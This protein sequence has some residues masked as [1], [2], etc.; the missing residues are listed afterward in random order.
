MG[1]KAK[2]SKKASGVGKPSS[3]AAETI[4]SFRLKGDRCYVEYRD[5]G[6][7]PLEIDLP[8]SEV[9]DVLSPALSEMAACRGM[10][11]PTTNPI[12]LAAWTAARADDTVLLL[13]NGTWFWLNPRA[14]TELAAGVA[15]VAAKCATFT[16]GST[17]QL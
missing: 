16:P 12:C 2:S 14:A 8:L 11:P 6:G 15:D 4:G 7:A 3:F 10:I 9:A 13:I 5:A 1:I 17:A